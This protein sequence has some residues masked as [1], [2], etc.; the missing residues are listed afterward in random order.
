ATLRHES[1]SRLVDDQR[2]AFVLVDVWG[3]TYE[4]T[5]EIV[6]V[7]VGTVRSRLARARARVEEELAAAHAHRATGHGSS[8]EGST[9]NGRVEREELEREAR[10]EAWRP[11]GDIVEQHADPPFAPPEERGVARGSEGR[12]A[13][14]HRV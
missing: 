11:R 10:P 8:C 7:P 5:A 9:T 12:S 13:S 1:L 6:G 14:V 4:E 2:V 3:H